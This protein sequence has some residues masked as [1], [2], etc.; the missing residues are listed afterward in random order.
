MAIDQE[1][2]LPVLGYIFEAV[3]A[4]FVLVADV[5]AVDVVPGFFTGLFPLLGLL[6]F[7]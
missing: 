3:L 2:I 5:G 1:S 7:K 6:I 4:G